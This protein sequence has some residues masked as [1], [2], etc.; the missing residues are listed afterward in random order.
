MH[1]QKMRSIVVAFILVMILSIC[2]IK[3]YLLLKKSKKEIN[4]MTA[5]TMFVIENSLFPGF[6]APHL[7]HLVASLLTSFPQSLHLTSAIFFIT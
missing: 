1:A 3:N 4:T 5:M 6:L 7:L 2:L